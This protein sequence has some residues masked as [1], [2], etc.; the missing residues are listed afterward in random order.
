MN[1]NNSITTIYLKQMNFSIDISKLNEQ[2]QVKRQQKQTLTKRTFDIIKLPSIQ[3]C[4]LQRLSDLSLYDQPQILVS[5][6]E[7]EYY[8]QFDSTQTIPFQIQL[9][10]IET[11]NVNDNNQNEMQENQLSSFISTNQS[12]I[13]LND[14]NQLMCF[15]QPNNPNNT[16]NNNNINTSLQINNQTQTQFFDELIIRIYNFCMKYQHIH[17]Q[18]TEENVMINDYP[19]AHLL[20]F[21]LTDEIDP[22]LQFP[23]PI[24]NSLFFISLLFN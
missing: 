7:Y 21:K 24:L 5:D 17:F 19:N 4:Q 16:L 13:Q 3:E 18:V 11:N 22:F 15:I 14:S 23:K 8:S 2:Q 12:D 1:Q 20:I 9:N 10:G 6:E